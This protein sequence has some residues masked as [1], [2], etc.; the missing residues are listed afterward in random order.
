MKRFNL[1]LVVIFCAL[2]LLCQSKSSLISKWELSGQSKFRFA[3]WDIYTAELF[4]PNGDYN[5]EQ[6]VAL[7]LTYHRDFKGE[8]T[9][10]PELREDLIGEKK[11]D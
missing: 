10:E 7:K 5:P 4:T 3:W 9:S 8:K 6:P 11:T 1:L 2:P